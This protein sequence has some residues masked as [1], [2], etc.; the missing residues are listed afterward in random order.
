MDA[1]EIQPGWSTRSLPLHKR[2][3]HQ[4]L[5]ADGELSQ[6]DPGLVARAYGLTRHVDFGGIQKGQSFHKLSIGFPNAQKAALCAT[7]RQSGRQHLLAR[8]VRGPLGQR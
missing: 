8:R 3:P 7:W 4:R 5:L 2:L 6:L 1:R